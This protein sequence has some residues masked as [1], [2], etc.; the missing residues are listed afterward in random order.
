LKPR[1]VWL[2]ALVLATPTWAQEAVP[3]ERPPISGTDLSRFIPDTASVEDGRRTLGSLPANLGRSF[4]GVFSSENLAPL[5][6]GAAAT[7]TAAP[8]DHVAQ[9]GLQGQAPG[10]SGAASTAG[11]FSVIAPATLGLFVAGRFAHDGRFRAFSYDAGQ[12]MIVNGVY[13]G[14][15]KKAGGRQRPDGSDSL[16]FPSGHSSSAFALATVADRHYGW[17]VGLPSYAA[18][19]AIALSRI[20]NNKHYLTDVLAGAT[21]GVICGRTVVRTN[22]EPVG[23]QR[24]LSLVP[25]ADPQGTGVG[26]GA[27][28][29][30]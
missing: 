1:S 18:A 10:I 20:S 17:K 7:A 16:S 12:A 8:F 26:V 24:Q 4:V 19:S 13:T 25:V 11:G 21:I 23:R 3:S 22:G 14:I 30:W 29:S 27:S 28:L 5:M 9:D 15:L 6:I 2:L